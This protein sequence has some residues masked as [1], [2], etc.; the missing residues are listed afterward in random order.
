[1]NPGKQTWNYQELVKE[2]SKAIRKRLGKT[3]ILSLKQT[4][5]EEHVK[6]NAKMTQKSGTSTSVQKV[7]FALTDKPLQMPLP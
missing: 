1:M 6:K 2:V 4:F 7:V 5:G 3:E